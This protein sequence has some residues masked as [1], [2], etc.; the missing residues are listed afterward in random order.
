L[1]KIDVY[2]LKHVF[3]CK[4]M[5]WASNLQNRH[6]KL[7]FYKLS[8]KP[9]IWYV[10][11]FEHGD[12]K[13]AV[14]SNLMKNVN[15]LSNWW[16]WCSNNEFHAFTL[17]ENEIDVQINKMHVLHDLSQVEQI[18]WKLVFVGFQAWRFQICCSLADVKIKLNHVLHAQTR[19]NMQIDVLNVKLVKSTLLT[20]LLHVVQKPWN[21]V[22]VRFSTWRFQICQY[23]KLDLN[24]QIA[25]KTMILHLYMQTSSNSCSI[26]M[27]DRKND[28]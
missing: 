14:C 1:S 2:M 6:Y 5:F 12:S 11:V 25:I 4:L 13:N 26:R 22:W 10:E 15:S 28:N 17:F 27:F 9:Q 19:F 20:Q 18:H 24:H 8:K 7:K 3:T 16:I 23:C 21:L